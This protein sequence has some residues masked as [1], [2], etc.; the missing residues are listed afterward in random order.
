[1]HALLLL[2]VIANSP[3]SHIPSFCLTFSPCSILNKACCGSNT[4][5]T[6]T[7]L[8]EILIYGTSHPQVHCNMCVHFNGT[9]VFLCSCVWPDCIHV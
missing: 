3:Y 9:R 6:K 2:Y 4:E 5:V 8:L 7:D 1:M